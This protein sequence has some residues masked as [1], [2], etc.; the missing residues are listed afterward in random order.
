[1]TLAKTIRLPAKFATRLPVRSQAFVA[2][3]FVRELEKSRI[4]L[5]QNIW[6][7]NITNIV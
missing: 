4:R 3:F 2:M 6:Q 7:H 1:M 5:T